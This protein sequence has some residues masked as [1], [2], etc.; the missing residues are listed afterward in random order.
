MAAGDP[1]AFELFGPPDFSPA[2]YHELAMRARSEPKR[3]A[4]PPP[5][6]QDSG[7][8]AE[9][10]YA[11]AAEMWAARDLGM[12]VHMQL[13]VD[14]KHVPLVF[15]VDPFKMSRSQH[16]GPWMAKLRVVYSGFNKETGEPV[17]GGRLI[18]GAGDKLADI[19]ILVEGSSDLGF[20]Y[21]GWISRPAF[22]KSCR[23][24]KVNGA[25]K[26]TLSA[27]RLWRI[28]HLKSQVLYNKRVATA[29]EMKYDDIVA[30]GYSGPDRRPYSVLHGDD[31]LGDPLLD[32]LE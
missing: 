22:E 19:V 23:L 1:G 14:R 13:L 4:E 32:S 27:D 11:Q 10:N 18:L 8:I 30:S 31:D 24:S 20:C 3:T 9:G 12:D 25:E 21:A 7:P 26:L 17:R 16:Y 2:G 15:D 28:S 6:R 29:E 5:Q